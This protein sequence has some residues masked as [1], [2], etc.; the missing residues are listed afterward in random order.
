MEPG[1]PWEYSDPVGE[2]L[3]P[4]GRQKSIGAVQ[5]DDRAEDAGILWC[6]EDEDLLLDWSESA[7]TGRLSVGFRTSPDALTPEPR[8]TGSAGTVARLEPPHPPIRGMGKRLSSRKCSPYTLD[9]MPGHFL[10]PE[11]SLP[12]TPRCVNRTGRLGA[13]SWLAWIPTRG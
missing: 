5:I 1:K 11:V 2:Y 13:S 8:F 6:I 10:Q 9:G 12:K 3:S 7:G 4:I